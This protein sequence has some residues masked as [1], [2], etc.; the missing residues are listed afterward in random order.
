[1]L[2]ALI[3]GCTDAPAMADLAKGRLKAKH[4]SLIVALTGLMGPHQRFLLKELLAHIDELDRHLS[5]LDREIRD[6]VAAYEDL[7]A[8]LDSIPGIDRRTA[9]AILAEIG[10]DVSRWPDADHLAAWGGLAPGQNESAGKR[11]SGRTRKGN[12][13]LRS[14]LILA[15]WA[16]SHTKGT[17]LGALYHRWARRMP[18]QKSDRGPGAPAAGDHLSRH[19][20]ART[21]SR[22]G[23]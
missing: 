19:S 18:P 9:E 23:G 8:L 21:L 16:A 2:E 17:F 15:A 20:D 6:R 1:M 5:A 22:L 11:R 13:T 14:A 10:P 3:A 12:V 7:I 4:A